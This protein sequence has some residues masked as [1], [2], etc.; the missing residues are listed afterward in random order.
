MET[1]TTKGTGIAVPLFVPLKAPR[2][3]STSH[4]SLIKWRRERKRYEQ[5]VAE[6]CNGDEE[7]MAEMLVSVKSS[8][9]DS[10]LSVLCDLEW[11]IDKDSVTDADLTKRLNDVI[12]SVKNDRV[13]NVAAEFKEA[14]KMNMQES[15]VRARVVQ[16]FADSRLFIEE[17]GWGDFFTDVKGKELRGKLLTNSIEPAMLRDDVKEI[18][19]V[20]NHAA[21]TDE[22]ELFR[23]VLKRALVHEDAFQRRKR[24]HGATRNEGKDAAA[25]GSDRPSKKARFK[26]AAQTTEQA[27]STPSKLVYPA[28]SVNVPKTPEGGCLNCKGAHWLVNCPSA[29]AE[30]KKELL[31]QRHAKRERDKAGRKGGDQH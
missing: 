14:V 30:E 5:Q 12:A 27:K 3:T 28:K 4:A 15:D 13:P 16:Y 17:R 21:L 31:R 11:V 24:Y 7:K 19:E 18:M 29:T 23:L 1:T 8:F 9:D 22:R 10:L 25:P 6:R 2:I 20:Q 26:Q